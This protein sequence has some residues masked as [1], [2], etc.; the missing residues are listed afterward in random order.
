MIP[1]QSQHINLLYYG[2]LLA[3][4]S[5]EINRGNVKH[6]QAP[7]A[8]PLGVVA[9]LTEELGEYAKAVIQEKP[10]E[11]KKELL[12]IAAVA[13]NHLLGTGPHFSSKE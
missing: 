7:L 13:I 9:I 3:E 12:Q 8:S 6:G 4:I 1:A 2:M 10:T 11:A 5:E